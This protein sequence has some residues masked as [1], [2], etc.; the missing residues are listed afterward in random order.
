[1]SDVL[2]CVAAIRSTRSVIVVLLTLSS[3]PL[4]LSREVSLS[5]RQYISLSRAVS[6][7]R[8]IYIS[9]TDSLALSLAPF[10]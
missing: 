4:S 1:M 3:L 6:L 8:A 10:L 5:H 2:M 9:L 7:S